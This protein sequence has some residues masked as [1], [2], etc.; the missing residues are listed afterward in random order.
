L[1]GIFLPAIDQERHPVMSSG[2]DLAKIGCSGDALALT[3]A[4]APLLPVSVVITTYNRSHLVGRAIQSALDQNWKQLEVLVIDDCSSDHTAEIVKSSYPDVRYVRQPVNGGLCA[5]RNRGIREASQPWVLFLD[6]DDEFEP[7]ALATIARRAA[8]LPGLDRYPLL[9]F[10]RSN[11]RMPAEFMIVSLQ[12]Y[13]TEEVLGDFAL[14][15]RKDFLL[16]EGLS[17]I[18]NLRNGNGLLLWHIARRYG[19]PTWS[20]RVQS[21]HAD[22]CDRATSAS[23]QMGN[24]V[25]YA[26]LQEYTLREFGEILAARFPRFRE[27]KRLGAATYR[28]LANQRPAARDHLRTALRERLSGAAIALWICS[29]LPLPI[30][31][32]CFRAYREH[33]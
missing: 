20:D 9:Q 31:R 13:L 33:T 25:N 3:E 30:A 26:E 24:A 2:F 19:I 16:S 5:A 7:G 6:D 28:L 17:Y 14:A 18:D 23:Y 8:Q 15:I 11:A 27:K 29:F 21:L 22:A 10:A 4:S 32:S 1:R 12:H